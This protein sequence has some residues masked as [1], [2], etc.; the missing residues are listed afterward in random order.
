[1]VPTVHISPSSAGKLI[2][3]CLVAL[4][5]VPALAA[6]Q[7][8]FSGIVVF[9]T[10]LSDPGNAVALN[11]E[12][13]T[14]H[15]FLVDPLLIPSAPYAKGGHHFSNGAT[16]IEQYARTVGLAGGAA[17]RW[18]ASVRPQ[19]L[20]LAARGLATTASIST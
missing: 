13:G 4:L 8:S 20:R 2:A 12:A 19:T 10:S 17:R 5:A 3:A 15:D 1:M 9:G 7:S 16:W 6:A 11:G 14:P 18:L